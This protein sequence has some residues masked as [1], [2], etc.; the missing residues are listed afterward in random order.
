MIRVLCAQDTHYGHRTSARAAASGLW[1]GYVYLSP[2]TSNRGTCDRVARMHD[3]ACATW[4]LGTCNMCSYMVSSLNKLSLHNYT[5]APNASA[6]KYCN[7]R[8]FKKRRE[9]RGGGGR[10][11]L[12]R[13]IRARVTDRL[14]AHMHILTH[15]H[16][17]SSRM[18]TH[19]HLEYPYTRRA[20]VKRKQK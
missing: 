12:S 5:H 19:T 9:R 3:E 2:N 18:P 8:T 1:L 14:W 16:W 20:H 10:G 11:P 4:D 13:G 17:N 6:H 15:E 7:E